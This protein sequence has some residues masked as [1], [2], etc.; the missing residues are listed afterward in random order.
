[1]RARSISAVMRF[2]LQGWLSLAVWC[3][4]SPFAQGQPPTW[5]RLP[6][7]PDPLGVAG[8]FVGVHEEVLI[9]AG[10]ANFPEGVPWRPTASGKRSPKTYH[11]RIYGLDLSGDNLCRVPLWQTSSDGLARPMGYG[12]SI[13]T[14]QGVLCIGGEWLEHHTDEYGAQPATLQRSNE[15]FLLKWSRETQTV[16]RVTTWSQ[17]EREYPLPSLPCGVSSACGA[18][19]GDVVY[20]A[21]GDCGEGGS[22][23]FLRL[24]L[25]A[26]QDN[27]HWEEL[28]TWPGPPRSHAIGIEVSGKFL[29]LSGR[30]KNAERGFELLADAYCFDPA[31]DFQSSKCSGWKRLADVGRPGESP[32]CVMGAT[33]AATAEGKVVVFGGDSGTELVEREQTLPRRLQQARKSGDDLLAATLQ[34]EIQARFEDHVGFSR[35]VLEFDLEQN[36]WRAA[37][38]LPFPTPVTTTAVR[39]A[40][41]FLLPTGEIRPGIR[42]N[43]V[44][45]LTFPLSQLDFGD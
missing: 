40:N 42:T 32:T 1:M 6:D 24:D 21:G 30:N 12:V 7:L 27:W 44:W 23:Q 41:C 14:E 17:G 2:V 5:S 43:Q 38:E 22:G 15:L 9:V 28:P 16:T 13:N 35:Q 37:G 19:I 8:P 18:T 10:G 25:G 29:L 31:L 36:A 11:D 20:L 34:A 26:P 4:L 3:A 45:A 33:A 39:W